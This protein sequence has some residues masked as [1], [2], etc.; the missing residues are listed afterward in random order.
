MMLLN[1]LLG[2]NFI[3]ENGIVERSNGFKSSATLLFL[4][5]VHVL[6]KG[7]RKYCQR[8]STSDMGFDLTQIFHIFTRTTYI[9]SNMRFQKKIWHTFHLT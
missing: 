9:Q 3:V 5:K 8:F 2:W 1:G 4:T 6:P 7:N